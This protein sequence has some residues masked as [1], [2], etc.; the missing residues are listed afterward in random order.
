M[1]HKKIR[2]FVKRSGRITTAQKH[3][4]DSMEH[5]GIVPKD[6]LDFQQ[7][8]NNNHPV[9]LDIGFGNGDALFEQA[10]NNTEY[11]FLGIE[12]YLAGI[13]SLLRRVKE[14]NLTNI[15]VM[16]HDAV[17]IVHNYI[18]KNSIAKLQLFFPDP[19]PKKKH[20]KRRIIQSDFL[21]CVHQILSNSG[22]LHIATDCVDYADYIHKLVMTS[23]LYEVTTSF[24]NNIN[25]YRPQTKFESKG[26]SQGNII[27][28]LMYQKII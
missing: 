19:W 7:I 28:D 9:I 21:I 17:E 3:G 4:L 18:P 2:S 12:V 14:A 1:Q 26:I 20:N 23:S 25:I 22:V 15:M 27:W 13:G 11:N 8:F 16:N 10:I 24:S 6:T 5:F